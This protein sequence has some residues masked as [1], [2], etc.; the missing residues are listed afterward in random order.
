MGPSLFGQVAG[1]CFWLNL[2]G[3][4][5]TFYGLYLRRKRPGTTSKGPAKGLT[6]R[7]QG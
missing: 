7:T 2:F 4:F 6:R 1:V 3:T 5:E